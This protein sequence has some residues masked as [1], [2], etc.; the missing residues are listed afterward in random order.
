MLSDGECGVPEKFM[1]EYLDDLN[2]MESTCWSI[3]V[4]GSSR[5][6]GA[7]MQMSENK[8][9]IISDLLSGEN[10]RGMFRGL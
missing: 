6:N 3:D 10:I 7:L 1:K 4:S 9:A 2:R 8:L 5:T